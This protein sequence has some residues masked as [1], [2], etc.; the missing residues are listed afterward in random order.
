MIG[1]RASRARVVLV[2]AIDSGQPRNSTGLPVLMCVAGIVL[3]GV[4]ARVTIPTAQA[5]R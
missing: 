2:N 1:R 3:G 4:L 5:N